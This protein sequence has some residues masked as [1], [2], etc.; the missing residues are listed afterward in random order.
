G[1]TQHLADTLAQWDIAAHRALVAPSAT[2]IQIVA[3]GEA[4]TTRATGVLLNAADPLE[5]RR[6][7]TGDP[8]RFREAITAAAD[9]WQDLA[10]TA[11]KS[12]SATAGD[13]GALDAFTSM[14]QSLGQI[15]RDGPNPAAVE[16][17]AQTIDLNVASQLS[18]QLLIAGADLAKAAEATVGN[19]GLHGST[20]ALMRQQREIQE[21]S[22]EVS[23]INPDQRLRDKTMPIPPKMR[24]PLRHASADVV[25]A[26]ERVA[27][28][29]MVAHQPGPSPAEPRKTP[30][31]RPEQLLGPSRP[32][33]PPCP[34]R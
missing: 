21:E 33:R 25:A 9:R 32:I 10:V 29:A 13:R 19:P 3:T 24:G 16:H 15:V 12:G 4:L 30:S 23:L 14:R 22:E 17:L 26:T 20:A 7:T 18:H 34:D 11:H 2:A 31:R 27:T 6:A 28:L 8:T 5:T 1:P